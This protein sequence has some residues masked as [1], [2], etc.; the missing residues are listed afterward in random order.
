M[1]PLLGVMR[2]LG[3]FIVA[4]RSACNAFCLR[5]ETNLAVR[6]VALLCH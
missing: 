1:L 5:Q 4:L 2:L 3:L 6:S